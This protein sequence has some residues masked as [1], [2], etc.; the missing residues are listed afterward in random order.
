MENI[1]TTTK[2]IQTTQPLIKLNLNNK[3]DDYHKYKGIEVSAPTYLKYKEEDDDTLSFSAEGIGSLYF[4]A[5][6][7]TDEGAQLTE[8]EKTALAEVISTN[9]NGT[10]DKLYQKFYSVYDTYE[11]QQSKKAYI[12][13]I[14]CNYTISKCT[15]KDKNAKSYFTAFFDPNSE[16]CYVITFFHLDAYEYDF[17][18]D[19]VNMLKNIKLIDFKAENNASDKLQINNTFLSKDWSGNSV[20][21]VEYIW[22]NTSSDTTCF[23]YDVITKCFQNGVECDK[24]FLCDDVDSGDSLKDVMP[25]Y[26]ATVRKGYVINDMSDVTIQCSELF[27]TKPFLETTIKLS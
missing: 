1:I 26:S 18:G 6:D 2:P 8:N 25:G 27:S 23:S 12:G 15:V 14:E 17:E 13:N 21:V 5:I 22:K 3:L 19:Y 7:P 10:F 16:L 24:A 11:K 4:V 9:K 20:L